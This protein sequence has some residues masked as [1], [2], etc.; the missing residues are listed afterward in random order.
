MARRIVLPMML[1][2]VV[3]FTTVAF[4]GAGIWI[5]FDLAS[6]ILVPIA[7]LLFM[8]LSS[9]WKG[10]I[11]AFKAPFLSKATRKDLLGSVSFFKS[12]GAAVWG[13]GVIGS[14]S[15]MIAILANL[16]DREKIGPNTAIALITTLYAAIFNTAM[17]LP[18]QSV[19]HRRAAGIDT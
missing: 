2:A 15:G 10:M 19:A 12:L 11:A 3:F 18:L 6:L 14:T 9:G 13:F 17:V 8:G 5:Y 16:T 7:P 1:V 4:T